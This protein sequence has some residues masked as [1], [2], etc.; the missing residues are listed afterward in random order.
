MPILTNFNSAAHHFFRCVVPQM[1]ERSDAIKHQLIAAGSLH[2]MSLRNTASTTHAERMVVKHYG[3]AL[4]E[5]ATAES[6]PTHVMLMSCL[7]FMAME[8]I[9]HENEAAVLHLQNGLRV[10]R[11]WKLARVSIAGSMPSA[12][13]ELIEVW[14]Q[15]IFAQLEAAASM[16]G[17]ASP[18]NDITPPEQLA[19]NTPCL[20]DRCSNLVQARE[21]F[22][23]IGMWLYF[24]A[25]RDPMCQTA[26]NPNL[27]HI[28][29]VWTTWYQKFLALWRQIPRNDERQQLQ[30]RL[31]D[32]HYRNHLVTLQAYALPAESAW[33]DYIEE[34]RWHV[35]VCA[36]I[37][38]ARASS[39]P[40][41]DS[42]LDFDLDP[43]VL[44]PMWQTAA[45]CRDSRTRHRALDL[46]RLHHKICGHND[47][48][49]AALIAEVIIDIEEA[50]LDNP[51]TSSASDIAEHKR[52]RTLE[53]DLSEPG[54][55]VLTFTRSPFLVH[56][57]VSV[58]FFTTGTPAVLPFKLFPLSESMRLAGYQ[59]LM[60]PKAQGCRCKSY[61]AR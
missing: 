60:R 47:D 26:G 33:D 45:C 39:P 46:I 40:A 17:K 52:I 16:T 50:H 58:P 44:P 56:E 36:G 21:K 8:S 24:S 59:G 12:D 1:G 2:E 9:K 57:T 48:C 38:A 31:L 7:L 3:Q 51:M 61:G 49:S 55:L 18:S 14:I 13:D 6:P 54:R 34:H 30:A 53:C 43:G 35:E 29:E 25:L 4:H 10:L 27:Q 32:V 15:P 42:K 23:E 37:L 11:E 41:L 28:L 22:F 20:P 19:W 5:L